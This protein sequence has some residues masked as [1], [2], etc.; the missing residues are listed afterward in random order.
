MIRINYFKTGTTAQRPATLTA[1][2]V[3]ALYYDTTIGKHVFWNG[4]GWVDYRAATQT[5]STATDVATLQADFNALLTK[6]KS[7]GL[8]A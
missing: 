3:G 8:M 4:S 1:T 2:Q 7:G 6:L 5:D